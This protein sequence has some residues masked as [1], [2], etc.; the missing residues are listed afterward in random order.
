MSAHYKVVYRGTAHRPNAFLGEPIVTDTSI[1]SQAAADGAVDPDR[2]LVGENPDSRNLEDALTWAAVYEELVRFKGTLLAA[3]YAA[4]REAT[5]S[6][7]T[8][9]RTTDLVILEA[10]ADRLRKRFDFWTARVTDLTAST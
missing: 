7:S 1:R 5:A 3:T 2:L 9:I 6:A 4:L 8:E 10:E